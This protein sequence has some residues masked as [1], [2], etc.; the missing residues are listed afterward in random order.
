MRCVRPFAA[1]VAALLAA[2]G[3]AA[4]CAGF[5]D[6]QDAESYCP[7]VQ[8]LRNRA[9]TTGCTTTTY[10][11]SDAV[12]RAAMALFLNRLGVALTQRL[13]FAEAALGAVN[14][15]AAPVL[16][17]TATVAAATYPR[18]AV[19]S[20]AFGGHAAGDA[21]FSLLPVVSTDDGSSW[22]PLGVV[23]IPE[24]TTSAAWGNASVVGTVQ[25]PA[26]QAVRFA[27][28]LDRESGTADFLQA[29]CQVLASVMNA[30]GTSSP[31]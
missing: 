5:T 28:R 1:L 2:P 7:A 13:A 12:T 17:Q 22:S 21:G 29:R 4:P 20:A 15:D 6:V 3:L 26:A 14:P 23:A 9:V 24:S 10:C 25:I 11:P 8:W 31:F 16:C 27:V 18:Q 30:N 19:V